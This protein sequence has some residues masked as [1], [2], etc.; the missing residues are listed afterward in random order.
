MPAE[1]RPSILVKREYL[2]KKATWY[3]QKWLLIP[4]SWGGDHPAQGTDCS[5]LAVEVLKSIG[6]L[7][8]NF[9]DTAQ[10]LYLRFKQYKKDYLNAGYLVFWFRDGKAIHVEMAIDEYHVI[11]ASGG[12]SK[13]LTIAD[14]IRNDAFVKMRPINYRGLEYKIVDPFRSIIE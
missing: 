11:G 7:P 6:I 2:R 10:G 5:G 9:D 13:T 1:H 4:Y 3:L 8:H 14:A 12:G